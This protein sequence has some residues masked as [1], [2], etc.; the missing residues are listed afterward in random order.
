VRE[1]RGLLAQVGNLRLVEIA[2][3]DCCGSAG[4]Y[5]LDQPA[6]AHALGQR[7]ARAVLA[8]G[9]SVVASGNIGCLTQLAT[10]L[11]A[12]AGGAAPRVVHTIELLDE[13]LRQARPHV[14]PA[15]NIAVHRPSEAL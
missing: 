5:N 15:S 6:L 3:G 9:A 8:T 10:H 7:K 1:P 13:A 4:T 14:S 12:I 2:D 11:G